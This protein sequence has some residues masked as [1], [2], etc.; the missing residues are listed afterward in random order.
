MYLPSHIF[1]LLDLACWHQVSEVNHNLKDTQN[2]E[3]FEESQQT[4]ETG[5][6][7]GDLNNPNTDA[8]EPEES[9]LSNVTIL[10]SGS[11][12]EW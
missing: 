6:V 8:E 12:T 1:L 10:G 11:F 7:S 4:M 9:T 3:S 2:K 5:I